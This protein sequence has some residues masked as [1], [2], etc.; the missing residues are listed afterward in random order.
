MMVNTH[1]DAEVCIS[2]GQL[3]FGRSI[4]DGELFY[5]ILLQIVVAV[6]VDEDDKC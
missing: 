2:D 1:I 5:A 6:K 4:F 3:L